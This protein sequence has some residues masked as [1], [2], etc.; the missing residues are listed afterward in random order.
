M[1]KNLHPYIREGYHCLQSLTLNPEQCCYSVSTSSMRSNWRGFRSRTRRF[2]TYAMKTFITY[3]D[4]CENLQNTYEDG[5][6]ISSQT[7]ANAIGVFVDKQETMSDWTAL[8]LTIDQIMYAA[9]DAVFL[10]MLPTVDKSA[11]KSK[12]S[13]MLLFF[14]R[15]EVNEEWSERCVNGQ[16]PSTSNG[17]C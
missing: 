7:V 5:C 16:M 13:S 6:E 8:C 17:V 3:I 9:F 4:Q 12:S 2:V 11:K 1:S 15:N 14:I 10:R